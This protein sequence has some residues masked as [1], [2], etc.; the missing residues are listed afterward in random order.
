MQLPI[1]I[2]SAERPEYDITENAA[3]TTRLI[4]ELEGR[5]YAVTLARGVW[6]GRSEVSLVVSLDSDRYVQWHIGELSAIAQRYQQDAIL[7]VAF[8]GRATLIYG[9]DTATDTDIGT[10]RTV[11]PSGLGLKGYTVI[12]GK[13]YAAV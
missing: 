3:R 2:L 6:E 5:D 4:G 13:Y 12:A 1:V 9:A 8:S 11:A 10:W 7:Y